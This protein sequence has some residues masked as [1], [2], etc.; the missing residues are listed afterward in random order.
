MNNSTTPIPGIIVPFFML[1]GLI[2]VTTA[3][4]TGCSTSKPDPVSLVEPEQTETAEIIAVPAKEIRVKAAHPIQ[5]TVKKGDTLWGISSLFLQDPWFWPE[6]WQK[7]PA[8]S[9]SP[10]NFSGGYINAGLC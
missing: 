10:L 9:K 6:I 4:I 1:L 3:L 5:Y 8:N 7:K 2:A